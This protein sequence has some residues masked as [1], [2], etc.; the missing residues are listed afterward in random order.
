M[1]E[2][3]QANK[4]E[5]HYYFDDSDDS[6]TMNAF[7]R[8]RCEFELLQIYTELQKELELDVRV[9][10]EAFEE[11]GLTELWTFLAENSVQITLLLTGLSQVL[12][13]V[14]IRKTKLEKKDLKLSTE[15][16]K[17]NI[18]VLK[19]EIKEK[20]PEQ[21]TIQNLNLIIDSNPKILKHL[22][23]YYK[24]LYNY[25]KVKKIS[26][27]KL[28]KNKEKIEDPKFISRTDFDKFVIESNELESEID[29]NATIEIISPVLKKGKYKWKGIYGKIGE[30]VDFYMKDKIFK[31]SI[32]AEG[33]E[34]KNG[35]FIDCILEKNRKINEVGEIYTSSY[36]VLTVLK[37]HYE[38]IVEE[39]PQGKKYRKEKEAEKQ[40]LKLFDNKDKKE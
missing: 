3:S 30:A 9:E 28:S 26:T 6:H 4:L 40:Q 20:E 25:P 11:G 37:K 16:R 15:E 5:L 35:T 13:R 14:P 36:S 24:Q 27:T 21:I 12:S 1:K 18:K 22:S 7:V 17:L 10:T 39:T 34:F 8:N 32:I 23:N 31:K 33:V 19:K 2:Q 29:E 38:N